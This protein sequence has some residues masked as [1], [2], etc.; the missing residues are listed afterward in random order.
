MKTKNFLTRL[1]AT[2][3]LRSILM[4]LILPCASFQRESY[5]APIRSETDAALQA[6]ASTPTNM[7]KAYL[8]GNCKRLEGTPYVV[9]FY[10]DDDVSSWTEEEVAIYNEQLISPALDFLDENAA[11]W[12]VD[13]CMKV[14][15]YASYSHPSRAVAY[16]GVI[17]NFNDGNT[18][19]DILDQAAVAAGFTS[20]EHMHECLT[21]HAGTDQI[22]YVIMVDK[23][24]RSYSCPR[25]GKNRNVSDEYELEYSVIFS[26]FTDTSRDSASDTVAHELLHLFG[27]EDYYYP[28]SRK[29]LA[30]K[31][32]PTDIMLCGM[33]D[34]AYFTLDAFTAYTLGWTDTVPEVCS[35]PGWWG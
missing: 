19:Q 29:A 14:G 30:E 13:L 25:Q 27:A 35:M 28:E 34:L 32:Y 2:V 17:E 18:S 8:S 12:G 26:G 21:E 5:I 31:F 16:D 23:G 6:L 3:L 22:A 11:Q 10:L 15:A 24:G 7:R 33:S 20:K 9:V 1:I 4:M